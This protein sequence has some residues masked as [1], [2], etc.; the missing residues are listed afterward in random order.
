MNRI[1]EVEGA[2][3]TDAEVEGLLDADDTDDGDGE[4]S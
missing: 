3:G 1:A 4:S 2:G